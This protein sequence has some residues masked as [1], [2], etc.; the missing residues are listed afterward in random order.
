MKKHAKFGEKMTARDT[1][2]NYLESFASGDPDKIAAHVSEDFCNNQTGELG[3]GCTG[4][5]AY[6]QRLVGFLDTFRHLRYEVGEVVCEG[7]RVAASYRLFAE[8]GGKAIEIPGVM[9]ITVLEGKIISRSDYWDGL[10]Y[11]KQT[12]KSA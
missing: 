5:D 9:M 2:L 6:R 4:R 11:L 10:T 1:A 8:D 12:G 3:R 7:D